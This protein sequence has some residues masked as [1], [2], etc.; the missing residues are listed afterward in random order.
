[1]EEKVLEI[2]RNVLDINSVDETCSQ[3]TCQNWD[4]MA[5][6]NI[7]VEL[8]TEFNVI[9]NP[10]DIAEMKSYADIVRLLKR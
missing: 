6:L 10:E 4:S 9:L 3:A 2:L 7:V 5:Q 8:E 1:M